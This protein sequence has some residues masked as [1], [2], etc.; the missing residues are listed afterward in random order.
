MCGD[1]SAN[2]CYM[3]NQRTLQMFWVSFTPI[4]KIRHN[5]HN[6]CFSLA[7]RSVWNFEVNASLS[8]SL[9]HLSQT[10]H[11]HSWRYLRTCEKITHFLLWKVQG[12]SL[13]SEQRWKLVCQVLRGWWPAGPLGLACGPC[14]CSEQTHCWRMLCCALQYV[15]FYEIFR[16]AVYLINRKAQAHGG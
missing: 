12:T 7:Q 4:C 16:N 3:N 8:L 14:L 13:L 15:S 1:C 6:L 5:P 10:T 9:I 11:Q 2:I